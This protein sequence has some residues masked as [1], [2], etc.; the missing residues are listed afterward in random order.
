M[1]VPCRRTL[2]GKWLS[3]DGRS[4]IIA[5]RGELAQERLDALWERERER[6][7]AWH[8][9]A[10][11]ERSQEFNRRL[12]FDEECGQHQ[13]RT[14]A[15][16]AANKAQ[17]AFQHQ[18]KKLLDAVAGELSNYGSGQVRAWGGCEHAWWCV[19][20]CVCARVGRRVRAWWCV[21]VCV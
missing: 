8:L 19:C 10:D 15:F 3:R 17:V 12:M 14:D 11:E 16:L 4:S 2:R 6:R 1:R 9:K 13:Q 21:Y 20:M 7:R 5:T 18:Q